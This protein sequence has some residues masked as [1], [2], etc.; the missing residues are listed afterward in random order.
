MKKKFDLAIFDLDGTLVNSLDDL[1]NAVNK[2]LE[3][4]GYPKHEMEKYRFFVGNGAAKLCERALPE[5][6]RTPEETARLL[7]RFGEIYG[8]NCFVLTAAY[9]GIPEMLEKLDLA[10]VTCAVASNKPDEFSQVVVS[11][12]LDMEHFA[13]VMG[14]REGVPTKPSPDIINNIISELGMKKE[15]AIVIG[16]SCVDVQTAHNSGLECIGCNWGFRGEKELKDNGCEYIAYK[17]EDI[18]KIILE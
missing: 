3:E 18:L 1:G 2:A 7:K 14:K 8:E 13:L 11:K 6:K 12:L 15:N 16:D 17:P 9:D 5:D 4:F 10:G